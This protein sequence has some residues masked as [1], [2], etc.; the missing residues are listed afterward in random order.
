MWSS[1]FQSLTS[2]PQ[3]LSVARIL[4]KV[5]YYRQE[6]EAMKT[7]DRQGQYSSAR[8]FQVSVWQFFWDV[9][10]RSVPDGV[11]IVCF[12]SHSSSQPGT[13]SCSPAKPEN[14]PSVSLLAARPSQ[15]SP[16]IGHHAIA[17]QARSG[18][19]LLVCSLSLFIFLFLRH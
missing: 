14:P 19:L 9:L 2:H 16:L 17:R 15:Q 18:C 11:W 7:C 3:I 12:H 4:V 6:F 1:V 10:R 8:L 5:F 13:A